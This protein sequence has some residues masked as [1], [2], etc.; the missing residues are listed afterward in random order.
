MSDISITGLELW[1]YHGVDEAEKAV[2]QTFVLDIAI[3]ADVEKA[4]R[5]DDLEDTVSYSAVIKTASAAFCENK[6]DLIERAAG[7]TADAILA[8]FDKVK[9]VGV[10]VHKPDAPM[11]AK[12]SDVSVTVRRERS[13]R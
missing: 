1:A 12:F 5:S 7:F 13:G 11:K 2:G 3:D 6:F 8:E 9:A 10:T 4:S